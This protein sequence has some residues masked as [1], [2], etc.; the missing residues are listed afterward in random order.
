MG[1]NIHFSE[2]SAPRKKDEI[3]K[4]FVIKKPSNYRVD[5]GLFTDALVGSDEI[6]GF[7]LKYAAGRKQLAFYR[8]DTSKEE[9]ARITKEERVQLDIPLEQ[10][11]LV[12]EPTEELASFVD[13]I[14]V[15]IKKFQ[16]VDIDK[17]G[18]ELADILNSQ[19]VRKTPDELKEISQQLVI[20]TIESIVISKLRNL[21]L[22]VFATKGYKIFENK[23]PQTRNRI[24]ENLKQE[25]AELYEKSHQKD[26]SIGID[27]LNKLIKK[28]T[29]LLK[30]ELG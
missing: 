8:Y 12:I 27:W 21:Q 26:F 18:R 24:L 29:E 19:Q 16:A 28:N 14:G 7:P 11:E 9:L 20:T 22:D 17:S 15:K 25:L 10:I 30:K 5:Y 13:N 4:I 3:G 6:T 1:K 2:S 23:Q